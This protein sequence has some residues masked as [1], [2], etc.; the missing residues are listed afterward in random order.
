MT[1]TS[2]EKHLANTDI[3][4][5]QHALKFLTEFVEFAH[6][7]CCIFKIETTKPETTFKHFAVIQSHSRS[8]EVEKVSVNLYLL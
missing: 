8:F 7:I 6:Y 5:P 1:T 3:E 4:I 2:K